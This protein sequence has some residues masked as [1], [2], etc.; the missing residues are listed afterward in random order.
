MK[1][2]DGVQ[3]TLGAGPVSCLV[4]EKEKEDLKET[5]SNQK[6]VWKMEGQRTE[7][8]FAEA[9]KWIILE[10]LQWGMPEKKK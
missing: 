10:E 2:E 7:R 9:C 4:L 3:M 6:N 8:K 1:I 5:H